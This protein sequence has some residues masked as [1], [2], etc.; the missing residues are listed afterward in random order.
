MPGRLLYQ[1]EAEQLVPEQSLVIVESKVPFSFVLGDLWNS[2]KK[3][4]NTEM[5]VYY[6]LKK[7]ISYARHM[8][9]IVQYLYRL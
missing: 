9:A 1:R 8:H 4:A 3:A 5:I 6:L 7:S 2:H